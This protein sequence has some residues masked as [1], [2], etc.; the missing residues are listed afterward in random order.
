M[1]V[2]AQ[3]NDFHLDERLRASTFNLVDWP[4]SRVLLKNNA[5][6]PWCILV[7][8]QPEK[9]EITELRQSDRYQLMEEIHQL[10]LIMQHMFMPDKLNIG[11]LG[12]IVAQMHI[13]VLARFKH[14]PVWP[15]GIWQSAAPEKSYVAADHLIAALVEQLSAVLF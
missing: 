10:S 11:S 3:I 7:P 1:P 14:D 4:L 6:Y 5:D 2:Q 13:H 8:R 15:H 9:T 12:N